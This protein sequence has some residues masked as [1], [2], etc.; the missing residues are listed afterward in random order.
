MCDPRQ[1][2]QHHGHVGFH[3]GCGCGPHTR[4]FFSKKEQQECLEKYRTVLED[5]LTGVKERIQELK[6]E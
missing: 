5:E 4:R 6:G 2:H 1:F 3:H